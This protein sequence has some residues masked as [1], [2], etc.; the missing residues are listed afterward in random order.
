[1]EWSLYVN[2][3]I[4]VQQLVQSHTIF[5]FPP[6]ML[7]A[8]Y[9]TTESESL[10]NVIRSVTKLRKLFPNDKSGMKVVYIALMQ[11][12]KKWTM[13]IQNWRGAMNRFEIEFC[14]LLTSHW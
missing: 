13:P 2:F 9:K 3:I 1:M 5:D 11:A 7:K 8:I 6:E 4:L 14:E 10:N 12:S